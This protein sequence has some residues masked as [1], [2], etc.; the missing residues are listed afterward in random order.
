M[1]DNEAAAHALVAQLSA[2]GVDTRRARRRSRGEGAVNVD[3]A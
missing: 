1:R 2:T 3:I